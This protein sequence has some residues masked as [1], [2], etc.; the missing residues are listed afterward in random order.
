MA[1]FIICLGIMSLQASVLIGVMLIIRKVFEKIRIG[2]KYLMPLWLLVFFFLVFPWK[3]S[4][5]VGVWNSAPADFHTETVEQLIQK[6]VSREPHITEQTKQQESYDAAKQ[7]TENEYKVQQSA[8][9]GQEVSARQNSVKVTANQIFFLAGIVWAIGLMILLA[10]SLVSYLLLKRKLQT[11][12][13][14]TENIYISDEISVPLVCGIFRPKIYLPSGIGEEHLVYVVA[15]EKTHIRRKDLAVKLVVFLIANIHWFN[16]L[17]WIGFHFFVKDMEMACDEE[18]LRR[19]GEEKS[20]DY[21]QALLQLSMG[22]RMF[23][24]APLAFSENS[25]KERIKN[26]LRSRKSIKIAAG[27]VVSVGILMTAMFMTKAESGI[28]EELVSDILEKNEETTLTFKRIND[29]VKK[30]Y[31]ILE[32]FT[33]E[34]HKYKASGDCD[35]EVLADYEDRIREMKR[36]I[37]TYYELTMNEWIIKDVENYNEIIQIRTSVGNLK[38]LLTYVEKQKEL[39]QDGD[40]K[41]VEELSGL[42]DTYNA[43]IEEIEELE[44]EAF[45]AVDAFNEINGNITDEEAFYDTYLQW[46]KTVMAY[47]YG[48]KASKGLNLPSAFPYYSNNMTLGYAI[49]DLD[50]DGVK[51]LLLVDGAPE[52]E[53]TEIFAIYTIQD[54]ELKLVLQG[55]A[56]LSHCYIC[57]NGAV[58]EESYESMY[59][60]TGSYKFYRYSLGEME[61]IEGVDKEGIEEKMNYIYYTSEKW[62]NNARYIREEKAEE[63]LSRYEYDKVTGTPIAEK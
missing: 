62:E 9:V 30:R 21:A 10:R 17:V 37:M 5:S 27:I 61:L 59:D 52:T 45:A 49:M 29:G 40:S 8:A 6:K 34:Y 1:D 25:I 14:E 11:G 63:I 12:I 56:N 18:T 26:V 51:E 54:K 55:D 57:K 32:D 38:Q 44:T 2:K 42:I 15:H 36:N 19:I 16:P 23:F 3:I 53:T 28:I 20:K 4:S 60:E 7:E 22:N 47:N 58:A 43:R 50:L 24:Q 39:V 35:K 41:Y 46:V 13:L 48:D 31:R 33:E